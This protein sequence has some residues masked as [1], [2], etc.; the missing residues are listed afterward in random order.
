MY[1]KLYK[2]VKYIM[3]FLKYE[4]N[5]NEKTPK[6]K[7]VFEIKTKKVK[8]RERNVNEMLENQKK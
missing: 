2:I 8:I 5:A 1:K 3:N 4:R 6:N 7:V